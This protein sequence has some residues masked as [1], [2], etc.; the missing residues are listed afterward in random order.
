VPLAD[1][2]NQKVLLLN[3]EMTGIR[4]CN[5]PTCYL[6]ATRWMCSMCSHALMYEFKWLVVYP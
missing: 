4:Q 6:D 2:T 1:G 3:S 5:S